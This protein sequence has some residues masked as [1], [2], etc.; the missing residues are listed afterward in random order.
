MRCVVRGRAN[1]FVGV[2][3]DLPQWAG[4]GGR[5][6]GGARAARDHLPRRPPGQPAPRRHRRGDPRP[7]G[8]GGRRRDR[9]GQDDPA[10]EDLSGAGSR[11]HDVPQG[12]RR[13]EASP[14]RAHRAHP[15]PSDRG[16]LGRRADRRRARAAAGAAVG[17]RLPGALHRPHQRRHP[18]QADD[19]RHPARRAAARPDAVAL[20]HDHHRRGPR[21]LAQ[22]RLPARLPQAAAAAPA[23]PQARHHLRDHRRAALLRALRRPR[24]DPG[25]D[26]RGERT[27]LPSGGPLP[28]VDG[29]A[30]G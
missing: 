28:A 4:H 22:H 17:G 2:R 24:R 27:D 25:A 18:R 23:G 8:R 29:T 1:G 21:A 10:A 7:P 16:A 3:A 20:R 14:R 13:Q 30:R 6:V 26:H 19:R 5:D 15:A 9:L 11:P 12:A